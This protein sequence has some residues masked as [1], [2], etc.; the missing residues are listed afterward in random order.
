M[1]YNAHP[2]RR[3]PRKGPKLT[4]YMRVMYVTNYGFA[5]QTIPN[6]NG[7]KKKSKLTRNMK[8]IYD[9]KL[10]QRS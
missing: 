1:S 6:A 10:K 9:A 3:A 5:S 2:V 7:P 8:V 4:E